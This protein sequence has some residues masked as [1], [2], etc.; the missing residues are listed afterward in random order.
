VLKDGSPSGGSHRGGKLTAALVVLQFALTVVLLAGAGLMV[1][2]FFA[3]Q[4]LNAFVRP[5][6]LFTARIQLPEGKG[7]RYERPDARRQFYEQLLPELRSL[8]GVTE[9]AAA[10]SF[11]GLGASRNSLEIEGRPNPDPKN[12]P[13]AAMIV[14]TPNYLAV[15]GVP[16]QLGRG[17]TETDGDPGKEV[18][19]VSRAF[20]AQHWPGENA[21][22]KR[23]RFFDGDKP[24]AW[25]TVVGVCADLVQDPNEKTQL[26]LVHVPYRQEPWGWMG[27]LL[28]SAGDP[29]ALAGPVRATVQKLD[30]DLPLFEVRTLS[31]ALAKQR[32]FLSVFGTMF[33]VFAATGLVMASVGIYA[34]V[35]Q[36]TARR[37]REIGI[38]MALGATVGNIARLVL[39]RGLFQLG[40][41]LA[42]G[43]AGA[44]AATRLMDKIGFL[45]GTSAHDPVVFAGITVLLGSLGVTACWLPARKAAKISPTEALRTE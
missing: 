11:P 23:F 21:V 24:K 16:L 33:S 27:L 26:P 38:R 42:L 3:A 30:G 28:R 43:L 10:A 17:F 4:S 9:V 35:A 12:P 41:G 40:L 13:R 5:E 7:E 8:P 19:I 20:A 29:S 1:R 44:L 2:S 45:V 15:L 25:L 32:W 31:A 6:S 34:V 36:T 18:V 39:S 14:Q 37:T 22:G